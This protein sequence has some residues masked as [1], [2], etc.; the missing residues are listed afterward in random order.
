MAR[1]ELLLA[2]R[3]HQPVRVGQLAD[4]LHLAPNTVSGLVQTLVEKGFV[5]RAPD[6]CDRRV[7]LVELTR[8]GGTQLADWE[9]AHE[10][11]IGHAL[12]QLPLADQASIMAA[13]PGLALLVDHL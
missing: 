9:Q 4:L 6:P 11:R 12:G 2:L 10:Q 5:T 7:A 1:V 13:L 8:A 3:E